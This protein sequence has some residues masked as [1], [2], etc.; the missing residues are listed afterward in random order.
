VY[1]W[2]KSKIEENVEIAHVLVVFLIGDFRMQL[3]FPCCD[4]HKSSVPIQKVVSGSAIVNKISNFTVFNY[5]LST[6]CEIYQKWG[7]S[8]E[9][10]FALGKEPV[11]VV[12]ITTPAG[13]ISSDER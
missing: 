8:E 3:S 13:F 1:K 10:V 9:L 7:G 12:G 5:D 2:S 11:D 6:Y 4:F